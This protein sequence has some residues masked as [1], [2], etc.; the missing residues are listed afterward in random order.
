MPT[1]CLH[2]DITIWYASAH[3]TSPTG[4]ASSAALDA[5]LVLLKQESMGKALHLAAKLHQ[6]SNEVC[7]VEGK[8]YM[9]SVYMLPCICACM[10]Q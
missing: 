7:I 8:L 9:R 5:V 4:T 6:T 2:D 1:Q 10:P 3:R